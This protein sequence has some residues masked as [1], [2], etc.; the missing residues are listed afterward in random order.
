MYSAALIQTMI[1]LPC[2]SFAGIQTQFL[3]LCRADCLPKTSGERG[4]ILLLFRSVPSKRG[5][6]T[7]YQNVIWLCQPC[8]VFDQPDFSEEN[9]TVRQRGRREIKREMNRDEV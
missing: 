2:Q 9:E 5:D 8:Q 1:A 6:E 4:K 7:K 3:D